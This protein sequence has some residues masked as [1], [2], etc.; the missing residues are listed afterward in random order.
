VTVDLAVTL[1][2]VELPSP[3]LT[4]AGTAGYGDELAGYGDLALLGAVVTKSLASFSWDGNAAPRVGSQGAAMLN[5]VGLAGPGVAAWRATELPALR[6]RGARVVAS[7]W[8]RSVSEF[9]EAATQLEGADVVAVEINAS[10]PNLHGEGIFAHSA[11]LTCELVVAA[12]AVGR[13]RWVKL[14]PNTDDL[15]GIAAAA[16]EAGAEGLVLVNT[17][18]GMAIDIDAQ[19]PVLGAASGGVSG[20]AL[21]PVAL[22]AIYECRAALPAVPIV[23]VGGVSSAEDAVAMLMAGAQAVEIGSACLAQPRAPWKIQ[24]DLVRWCH[25]HHVTAVRDLSGRAHG[26]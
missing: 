1:G 19:R 25:R 24:R 10:C 4:A 9:L 13:P 14:S 3:L 2:T 15:V 26:G 22:R 23:G 5:S 11:S 20:A 17:L 12:G 16:V 6:A 8:G 7:I 18:R 21:L